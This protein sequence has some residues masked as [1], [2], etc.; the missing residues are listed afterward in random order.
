MPDALL[1][2]LDADGERMGMSLDGA[3]KEQAIGGSFHTD[4]SPLPFFEVFQRRTGL[5][6]SYRAIFA[7]G[8]CR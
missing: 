2:R 4:G 6:A 8:Y 5:R 1:D 3:T 7:Q